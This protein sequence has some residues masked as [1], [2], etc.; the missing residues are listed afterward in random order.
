MRIQTAYATTAAP[1]VKAPAE[2]GTAG[3]E[4][5]FLRAMKEI[6]EGERFL[7]KV[8]RGAMRGKD[9]SVQEMIAIQVGVFSTTQKIELF[10]KLVDRAS[11]CVRQLLAPQ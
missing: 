8:V 5:K 10:S 7:D 2:G 11:S 1:A 6:E 3:A 4:G 9:Y